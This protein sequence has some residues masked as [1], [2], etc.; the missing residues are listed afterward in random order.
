MYTIYNR[1]KSAIKMLK[2]CSATFINC[3]VVVKL[4]IWITFGNRLYM[5]N[6]WLFFRKV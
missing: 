5:K 1:K 4:N 3:Q 2:K 6:K